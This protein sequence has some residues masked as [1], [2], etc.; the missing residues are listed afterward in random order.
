MSYASGVSGTVTVAGPPD[1]ELDVIQWGRKKSSRLGET[2]N[3]TTNGFATYLGGTREGQGTIE[4]VWDSTKAPED[5]G[6][7]E[8]TTFT[9]D[10]VIGNSSVAYT[11]VPCIVESVEPK[12]NPRSGEAVTYSLS[13]RT[14]G[15][16][17]DP[18]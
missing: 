9:A 5:I 3:S 2:T 11:A 17:P 12:V 13:Y 10:L 15:D 18:A 6:L 8:G 1:V 16:I 7:T 4:V 14:N